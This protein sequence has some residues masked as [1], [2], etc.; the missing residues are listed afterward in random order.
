ML[1]MAGVM[2]NAHRTAWELFYGEIPKG[3]VVRHHCDHRACINPEH[4]AVGTQADNV[5]DMMVRGRW[6]GAG[7]AGMK[8]R[9][10]SPASGPV[11][12]EA[13]HCAQLTA[14]QAREIRE[15]YAVGGMSQYALARDYGV[16][17]SA[18]A[19]IVQGKTWKHA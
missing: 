13:H 11:R 10:H 8:R 19:H 18:I 9:R 17:R 7:S 15:R 1:T 4:L 16:S 12:G 2:R 6:G 3:L 5:A 14:D